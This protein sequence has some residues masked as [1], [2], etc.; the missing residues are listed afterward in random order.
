VCRRCRGGSSNM[1]FLYIYC[2][3]FFKNK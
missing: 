3:S 2:F 1:I